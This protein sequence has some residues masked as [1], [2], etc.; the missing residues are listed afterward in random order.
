LTNQR[1]KNHPSH[2]SI[3]KSKTKISCVLSSKLRRKKQAQDFVDRLEVAGGDT[4]SLLVIDK[5]A[6]KRSS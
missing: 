6:G 3:P 5:S 4:A 2:R 1:A